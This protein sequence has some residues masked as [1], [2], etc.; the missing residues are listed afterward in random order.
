MDGRMVNEANSQKIED[1]VLAEATAWL[2]KLQDG[3]RTRADEDAFRE[4]LAADHAHVQAFSRAS[5]FWE[6]LPAMGQRWRVEQASQPNRRVRRAG[7]MLVRAAVL[8]LFAV[9]LSM[10]IWMWRVPSYTTG[11]GQQQS[12]ALTDGTQVEINT[13]SRLAVEYTKDE[14][15]IV[16]TQGEALFRVAKVADRPFIVRAG[17]R[18]VRALGTTFIVRHE[19]QRVAVTLL[20]GQVEVFELTAASTAAAAVVVLAPGERAMLTSG[21]SPIVDRPQLDAVT[22][23]RRGEVVFDDVALADAI[24]EMNRYSQ[25]R[26]SAPQASVARLRVS[27]VFDARETEEFARMMAALHRLHLQRDGSHLQLMH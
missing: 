12:M 24:A 17:D 22:A 10:A 11:I 13:D 14:R 15:R 4:W 2:V 9:G 3:Q 18:E 19:K 6:L 23:W 20:E 16:L 5:D 27:G 26:I 25:L 1:V 21:S 7:M 8:A